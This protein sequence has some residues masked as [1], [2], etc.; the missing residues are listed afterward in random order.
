MSKFSFNSLRR[1][2]FFQ[3]DFSFFGPVYHRTGPVYRSNRSVYRSGPIALRDLNSNLRSPGFRP[4]PDHRTGQPVP[5]LA[6]SV[7]SVG[8][9]NPGHGQQGAS[10]AP[11]PCTTQASQCCAR[12]RLAHLFF[13]FIFI[14]TKYDTYV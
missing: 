8:S 3:S 11:A 6:G 7:R 13:P 5:D 10:H 12:C 2:I 1:T 14:P 9:V 4:V